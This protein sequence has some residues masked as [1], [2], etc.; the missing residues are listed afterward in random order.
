MIKKRIL[1][2]V[3]IAISISS[4]YA[5]D[6]TIEKKVNELLKKMT[7]EE[8][9]G[10]LNQYSGRAVTGPASNQKTNLQEEIKN[11]WV[12]SMLNVKGVKDT[13]EVQDLAMQSRLK[14]PLAFWIGCDTWI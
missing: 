10:Q 13:K 5:Q 2:I 3:S 4:L 6:P 12:G 9:V 1:A 11:G 8:K 14:D 7:I